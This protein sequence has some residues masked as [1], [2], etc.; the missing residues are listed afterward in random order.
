[1]SIR[2]LI[3]EIDTASLNVTEFCR[4][5]G[6][7]TWFFWDLRRRHR[8]E[9]DVVL[10]TRSRAPHRVANKTSLEVEDEVVRTR[11]HLVDVG[12]DA[13][14][15][16]IQFALRDLPGVPSES[17]IWRILSARGLITPDPTKA[18]KRSRRRFTA[19]RANECW[20]LDHTS[21][22]L[23]DGTEVKILNI[24][25][26]HSRLLVA[27]VATLSGTGAHALEVFAQAAAVLGWPERFLSDNAKA[28]R[29]VLADALAPL[30]IAAGHSRPYHPQT[31]GKV[32]RFH[33][34]LKRWLAQQPSATG[35]AEL[36]DQLDVFRHI[37]NHHRPHRSLTRQFPATVWELAPKSGPANRPIGQA[38]TVTTTTVNYSRVFSH[39]W[40][41]SIPGKHNGHSALI[42]IT[43]RTC[44]VFIDGQLERTLTLDP[45]RRTQTLYD[46]PGRPPTPTVREDPR[47][48]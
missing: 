8:I 3:V 29:Y 35:V 38:T 45:N 25:D 30:G 34:T 44:H 12:L 7:S 31:C 46:R 37:Y 18:P 5:H 15:A 16:S 42:A 27:S 21:W 36:Q 23:G 39:G 33:Q 19:E 11:K 24:V 47:H 32:E 26:D 10:E 40:A 9:G 1:V 43:G 2:R 14:P 48:P 20:Q 41:I 28:F 13:G 4:S 6:V 22:V 17:T